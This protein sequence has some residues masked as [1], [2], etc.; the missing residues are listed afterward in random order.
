MSDFLMGDLILV[1]YVIGWA[2]ARIWYLHGPGKPKA[3]KDERK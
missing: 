1:A 3:P 2:S